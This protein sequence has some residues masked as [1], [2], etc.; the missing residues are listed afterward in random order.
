MELML[1][2]IAHTKGGLG[3]EEVVETVLQG[4]KRMEAKYPIS[5]GVVIYVTSDEDGNP[6]LR[7]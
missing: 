6:V 1:R 7:A 4:K 2:P 5:S 3:M